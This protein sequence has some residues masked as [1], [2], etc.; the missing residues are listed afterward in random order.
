MLD[1]ERLGQPWHAFEQN[2]PVGQQAG[3]KSIHEVFL[4]DDN[5]G[6]LILEWLDPGAGFLDL[7]RDFRSGGHEGGIRRNSVSSVQ[8]LDTGSY[9]E[10]PTSRSLHFDQITAMSRASAA[11]AAATR[12]TRSDRGL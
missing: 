1:G 12:P 11:T 5:P 9:R 6:D 10:R 8:A 3:E 4:T 2:V 7:L